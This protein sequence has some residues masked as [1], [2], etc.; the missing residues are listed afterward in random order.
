MKI[1]SLCGCLK[2]DAQRFHWPKHRA[3]IIQTT[4]KHYRQHPKCLNK[5]LNDP[6]WKAKCPISE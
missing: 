2:F 3:I 4:E 5:A 1:V 6:V